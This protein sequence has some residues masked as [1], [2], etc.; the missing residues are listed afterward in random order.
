MA[1]RLCQ[2]DRVYKVG[3]AQAIAA[4]A[5]GTETVPKVDKIFGPGN[6]FVTQA[7]LLVAQDPAGATSDMPAGPSEVLIISDGSCSASFTAADLLSQAEH[8]SDSQVVLVSTSA[9][10]LSDVARE[11]EIHLATLGRETIARAALEKSLFIEVQDLDEAFEVSNTYAP[12]HLILQ[13]DNARAGSSRV[14]N[15]GSVFL[16]TYSAE[17]VGDYASG[18]NH[19]LPTYGYARSMSGL[20][21]ESF[22]KSISFQELSSEALIDIGPTV[23][24]LAQLEGLDAHALAVAVRRKSLLAEVEG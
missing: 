17:A 15:A 3:G 2:I 9:A 12:E 14:Q 4:L 18:T 24:T 1:A 11:L 16:G 6:S 7:K 13:I 20:S 10:V 5:Y 19:V 22:F 21:L 23:E 8:G